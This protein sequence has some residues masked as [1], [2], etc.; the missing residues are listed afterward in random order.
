MSALDLCER[1]TIVVATHDGPDAIPSWRYRDLACHNGLGGE[2][3]RWVITHLPSGLAFTQLGSFEKI[4]D[5]AAALVEVALL[6]N[7]WPY[8]ERDDLQRI[9]EQVRPIF[10][11]HNAKPRLSRHGGTIYGPGKKVVGRPLN[12]FDGLEKR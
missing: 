11:K 5:A 7:D 10:R 2:A 1:E 9:A 12:G 4:E 3:G 8:I 6:R